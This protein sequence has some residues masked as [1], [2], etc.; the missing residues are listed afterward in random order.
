MASGAQIKS[1]NISGGSSVGDPLRAQLFGLD[2]LFDLQGKPVLIEA[3]VSPQFQHA[4]EMEGLRRDV[5][6]PMLDGLAD[7]LAAVSAG[8]A[9]P[10]TGASGRWSH[11]ADL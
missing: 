2:F 10:D 11:L 3:N 4:K 7:A 5:A 8:D 9:L 1:S 6:V